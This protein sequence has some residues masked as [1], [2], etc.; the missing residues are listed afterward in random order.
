MLSATSI[1]ALTTLIGVVVTLI[2]AITL[3]VRQTQLK[4]TVDVVHQNTNSTLAA[5]SSKQDQMLATQATA[6]ELAARPPM[7]AALDPAPALRILP[8]PPHAARG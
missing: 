1:Q 8:G 6:V 3:L 5:L 4:T 2:T 7:P